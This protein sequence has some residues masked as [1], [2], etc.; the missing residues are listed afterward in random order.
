MQKVQKPLIMFNFLQE[1]TT[2]VSTITFAVKGCSELKATD[3]AKC[4]QI[5]HPGKHTMHI[6]T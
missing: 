4:S 5:R 6:F 2:G 1:G 3:K